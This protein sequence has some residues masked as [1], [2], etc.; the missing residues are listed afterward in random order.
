M[1]PLSDARMTLPALVVAI[2]ARLRPLVFPQWNEPPD[3]RE[4]RSEQQA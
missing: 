1:A 3:S 4:Q 2:Q